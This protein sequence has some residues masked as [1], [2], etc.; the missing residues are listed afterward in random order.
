MS[1]LHRVTLVSPYE[2]KFFDHYM[3]QPLS[4]ILG[5]EWWAWIGC[6]LGGRRHLCRAG[7]SDSD[8]PCF[9]LIFTQC[10]RVWGKRFS[11]WGHVPTLLSGGSW[12]HQAFSWEHA[13]FGGELH[14][15]CKLAC[16]GRVSCSCFGFILCLVF[17]CLPLPSPLIV[18]WSFP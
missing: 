16:C 2:S 3:Y 17:V 4:D 13:F 7:R 9:E 5:Y 14:F 10:F 8:T 6:S 1:G 18:V 11:V 12:S 15:R